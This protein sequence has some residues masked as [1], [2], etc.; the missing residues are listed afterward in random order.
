[1]QRPEKD[2]SFLQKRTHFLIH[3]SYLITPWN[4]RIIDPVSLRKIDRV[5]VRNCS[6]I[7]RNFRNSG[8]PENPYKYRRG[9]FFLPWSAKCRN[10]S[11]FLGI[12]EFLGFSWI[13]MIRGRFVRITEVRWAE[14]LHVS[15]RTFLSLFAL[16]SAVVPYVLSVCVRTRHPR[17]FPWYAQL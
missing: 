12:P 1:M 2:S 13:S 6:G 9:Y 17:S 15:V 14:G 8:I 4:S 10:S 11:E 3:D 16:L 5:A 7:S